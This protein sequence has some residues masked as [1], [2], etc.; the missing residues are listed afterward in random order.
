MFQK[1]NY[2]LMW[3]G[4]RTNQRKEGMVV[5][6]ATQG[7]KSVDIPTNVYCLKCHFS[8]GKVTDGN[9]HNEG[10]NAM[11]MQILTDVENTEIEAF[12]KDIDMTVQRIYSMYYENLNTSL[13]LTK[14]CE[15]ILSVSTNRRQVTRD[16]YNGVV[17][18]AEEFSPGITLEDMDLN[19]LKRFETWC[20]QNELSENTV[21]AC[22]K[23]FRTLFNEAIK[24]DLLKPWQT[25][26]RFYPIPEVRYRTDV[27]RFQEIVD[28]MDYEFKGEDRRFCHIRDLFCFAC[29]TGLR[30]SDLLRLTN[31]NISEVGGVTWLRIHTQKTGAYVQIPLSI[32]FYG[33]AMDIM[34]RYPSVS[35]MVAYADRTGI[36]KAIPKMLSVTGI[37]G[38]QHITIHTARR[39][40]I[41]ALAD[42][43][44][45][46]Y[47]IQ[48][49]VGHQRPTTT[50]KYMQLSTA[51]IQ[52]ELQRIFVRDVMKDQHEV[53]CTRK[54]GQ[55]L[56]ADSDYLRCKNCAMCREYKC[57]KFKC[58]RTKTITHTY[59]WCR[60]FKEKKN[61]GKH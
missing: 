28:L 34:R 30:V 36:N 19:W 60:K 14:F 44:A 12:R 31:D 18:K 35:E 57:G 51:S 24:R 4:T 27:L 50:A 7:K 43:G 23:V 59:D 2:E 21:W 9:P 58:M 49:L 1:I 39:S 37:G 45:N 52:N 42:F 47:T 48:K 61:E 11:L 29:F 10:L 33:H 40:C 17:R 22:M 13:P 56:Y 55:R 46:I 32:I 6:H 20:L 3:D 54:N 26:F 8:D 38:S 16:R 25:P 15:S 53:I 5:V 41:T